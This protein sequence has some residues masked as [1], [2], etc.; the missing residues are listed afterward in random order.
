M[1]SARWPYGW[2]N[3]ARVAADCVLR[4]RVGHS[5]AHV[6]DPMVAVGR[7]AV[8]LGRRNTCAHG[9]QRE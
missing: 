5:P 8:D 2:V 6:R 7:S 9:L 3:P 1:V 4:G